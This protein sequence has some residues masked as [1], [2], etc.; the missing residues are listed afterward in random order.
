MK[1]LNK[2]QAE[3]MF[4]AMCALNNVY[5]SFEF[6][7]STAAGDYIVVKDDPVTNAVTVRL[8]DCSKVEVY[9]NQVAFATAYEIEI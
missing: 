7:V 4:N 6:Y 1:L 8:A 2:S 5:A 3:G 9:V